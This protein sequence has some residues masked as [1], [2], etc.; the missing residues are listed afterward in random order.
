M[1]QVHLILMAA[2]GLC[3]ALG[4]AIAAPFAPGGVFS[5]ER[6]MQRQGLMLM[7]ITASE[8]FNQG[9]PRSFDRR[10][11]DDAA[12]PA[13]ATFYPGFRPKYVLLINLTDR[14]SYEWYWGM[15][16]GDYIKTVAAGTRTLETDDVMV[17]EDDEGARPSIALA[18]SIL[19]QNKQYHLRATA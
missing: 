11:L 2:I 17:V 13:A 4:R 5:I 3:A 18:A 19:L 16:E 6:H 8:S 1:K 14:I 7:A 12:A 10:F 9:Q 15:A